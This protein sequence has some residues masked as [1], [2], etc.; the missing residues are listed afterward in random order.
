[1]NY[2]QNAQEFAQKHGIKLVINSVEYRK[3]F[4]EDKGP[5]YVFNCTLMRNKKRYTF[6]FGQSISSGD[7]EPTM[8]DVLSCLHTS[9][10][11]TFDEFCGEFGYNNDSRSA[12]RVYKAVCK[13]YEAVTRLFSD[14]IE[15][16][17]EIQ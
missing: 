10:V 1:M 15:E 11:G 6:D 4:T 13:E 12:E 8:Y 7:T 3:H 16:L 5:R 9:E 17:Q 14:I 2:E